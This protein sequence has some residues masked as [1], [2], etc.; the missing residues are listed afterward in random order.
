MVLRSLLRS[1]WRKVEEATWEKHTWTVGVA[2][3]VPMVSREDE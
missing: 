3:E 2:V 1:A